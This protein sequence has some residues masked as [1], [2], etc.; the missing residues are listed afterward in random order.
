MMGHRNKNIYHKY[1]YN[2]IKYFLLIIRELSQ[3]DKFIM[4]KNIYNS[5]NS[6]DVE[7]ALV[8]LTGALLQLTY[9][10]TETVI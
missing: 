3:D 5:I 2:K 4:I 6:E 8:Q 1:L 9:G 7:Y 10:V